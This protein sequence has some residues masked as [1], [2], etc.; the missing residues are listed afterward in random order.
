MAAQLSDGHAKNE[1]QSGEEGRDEGGV[2]RE[3]RAF[4]GVGKGEEGETTAERR[5]Q[6]EVRS[7]GR[8]SDAHVGDGT[9]Q[10]DPDWHK[11][12][13][14]VRRQGVVRDEGRVDGCDAEEEEREVGV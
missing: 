12:G 10:G 4:F 1:N 3:E 14:S 5:G 2:R 7:V 11:H 6:R 9:E 13:A 8:N